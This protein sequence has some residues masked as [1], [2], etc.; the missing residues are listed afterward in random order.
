VKLAW[1]PN[2]PSKPNVNGYGLKVVGYFTPAD[3]QSLADLDLDLGSGG[4]VLLPGTAGSAAAPNL[5]VEGSKAGTLYLLNRDNLA[6]FNPTADQALGE[7]PDFTAAGVRAAVFLNTPAYFDGMLYIAGSG[8]TLKAL[9]ISNGAFG[10]VSSQSP[11]AFG[12]RGGTPSISADGTTDGIVWVVDPTSNELRAY[13][14]ANVAREVYNSDQAPAVRD[15]LGGATKFSVPTVADGQV[16]VGTG[17]SLVIYGLLP[18]TNSPTDRYIAAAYYDVLG[19]SVDSASL[20]YWNGLLVAGTPSS[21]LAST[22][23]HSHEYDATM[24]ITPAYERFLGR[25]P[26]AAGLAWWVAQLQNGLT[27]EQLEADLIGSPEFYARAGG[28]DR[29][30]IEALYNDVLGRGADSQGEAYW[31]AQLAAGASRYNLAYAF[32]TGVESEEQRI[33]DDY[34]H[35]LGRAPDGPGISYWLAQVAN[36]MTD[37]DRAAAFVASQEYYDEHE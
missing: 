10:R 19:R 13:D 6:G 9:P 30:W 37:E 4:T 24:V 29:S 3:Q 27:D 11:D 34:E 12:S 22:L 8:D 16:F 21:L 17:N 14:A 31:V 5:L 23:V 33:V 35:Y 36:G 20:A 18:A 2:G 15:Q 32:A 7:I 25:L 1:D 28:T 26:D